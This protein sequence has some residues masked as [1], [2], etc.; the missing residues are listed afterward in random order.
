MKLPGFRGLLAMIAI[1]CLFACV[2]RKK[3]PSDILPTDKMEAV[4]W[5]MVLADRFA[6]QFVIRDTPRVNLKDETFKLYS[7]VFAIH[8]VS[9]EEFT[10]SYKFY[11]TRPDLSRVMFD[12][13]Y[14][15]ANRK[16]EEAYRPK[17]DK[18]LD[19]TAGKDSSKNAT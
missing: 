18:P 12:S 1:V 9:R 5:D 8:K 10:K 13:I 11:M 19:T 14:A 3:V 16:K 4:I 7:E 15:R 17:M 6:S 2:D